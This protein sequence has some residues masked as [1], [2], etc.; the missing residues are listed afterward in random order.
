MSVLKARHVNAVLPDKASLPGWRQVGSRSVDESGSLCEAV[1]GD[2]CESVIATGAAN[3]TRGPQKTDTWLRFSFT[4][5]SCRTEGAAQ[6]LYKALTDDDPRP[7]GAGGPQFGDESAVS[8][9]LLD[10]EYPVAYIH[11]KVRVGSTVLWTYAMGS[12][13]AVTSERAEMAAK[14][15]TQRVQQAHKGLEPTASADVP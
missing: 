13:K 5:Y 4:V 12:E 1:A 11:N 3:F 7:D 15:Q 14:L 6:R 8:S 2:A 9:D 10:G